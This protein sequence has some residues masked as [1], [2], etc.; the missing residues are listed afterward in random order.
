MDKAILCERLVRYLRLYTH[1]VGVKLYKDRSLVPRRARKETRNICQFIS[2]ARYQD[3]ISVGYAESIMCAIGASCLGLIK[4][5]EVFTSGKAAV[6]RYCKNASVGKKF[7]ENTFKIGD[8]GKQ[9]DAVL[10][11]SLR[12]LSVEPDVV[13]VYGQPVQIMRL[14]HAHVYDTG[15]KISADTVAEAAVCSSIAWTHTYKKPA[16]GIP[17]RGDRAYGGTQPSEIVFTFPYSE[18]ERLV[19]NLEA[20]GGENTLPIAPHMD[21]ETP[22]MGDYAMKKEYLL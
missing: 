14:I 3:R 2:Q 17:C 6:G 13:V 16:M 7:F 10:I 12:R 22:N 20:L 18:L 19:S 11:G 21:W 5:P 4:T 15:E 9:Y 8:S 1:P